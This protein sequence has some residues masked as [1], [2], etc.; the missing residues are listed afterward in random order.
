MD[1]DQ[2]RRYILAARIDGFGSVAGDAGLDR[3]D[4]A[5]DRAGFGRPERN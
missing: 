5:G 1:V 2:A 4:A 3:R